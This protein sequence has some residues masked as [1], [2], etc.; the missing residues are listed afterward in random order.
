MEFCGT[1]DETRGKRITRKAHDAEMRAFG[2][3]LRERTYAWLHV[4]RR[5]KI[6]HD[7]ARLIGEKLPGVDVPVAYYLKWRAE[8]EQ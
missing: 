1:T 3:D 6:C 2:D 8:N 5:L 7:I 4:A